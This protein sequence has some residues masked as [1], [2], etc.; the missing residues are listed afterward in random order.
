MAEPRDRYSAVSILLH[1]TIAALILGNVYAGWVMAHAKGLEKFQVFQLHKSIGLTVLVLSLARLGWRL[2]NP[3]PPLPAHMAR[4]EKRFAHSVQV[5]LYLLMIGI[6]ALGW[7][8]VS[9]SPLNI[10]TEFWGVVPWPE[11]PL[12]NSKAL[13]DQLGDV[14]IYLVVA[15]FG[16][17]ALHV[18]GA[19]KHQFLDRDQ[20]LWRMLPIVGRPH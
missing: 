12:P 20:V 1:W 3:A 10:P 18:A 15:M 2:I 4:W 16:I 14:H 13:S 9:S 17:L 6:P 8:T 11:L 19:L 7:A 5:A